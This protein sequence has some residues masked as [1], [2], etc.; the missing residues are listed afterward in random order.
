MELTPS[1]QTKPL[2]KPARLKKNLSRSPHLPPRVCSPPRLPRRV[3]S[4]AL[5][6]VS[7][8]A[9]GPMP[10]D[11]GLRRTRRVRNEYLRRSPPTSALQRFLHF[12]CGSWN[13]HFY[14]EAN[15]SAIVPPAD[16]LNSV[17]SEA[18][19]LTPRNRGLRRNERG[20]KLIFASVDADLYPSKIRFYLEAKQC[21]GATC[22]CF[23]LCL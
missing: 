20:E 11:R 7:S 13:L 21:H 8:E 22:R 4:H 16:A 19:D 12:P 3:R 14:L 5:I 6:S 9:T 17:S 1:I 2:A 15:D 10:R 18:T 23:G